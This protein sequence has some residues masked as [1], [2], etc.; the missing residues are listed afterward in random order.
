MDKIVDCIAGELGDPL[1]SVQNVP[2]GTDRH[3]PLTHALDQY[4][5]G[6]ISTFQHDD[7]RTF[8]ALDHHNGVDLP[9]MDGING[10]NRIVVRNY[11]RYEF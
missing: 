1:I 7:L 2:I 4:L 10:F 6:P 8:D 9:M 3:C 11:M 5:I